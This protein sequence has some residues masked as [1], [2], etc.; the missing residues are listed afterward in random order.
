MFLNGSLNTG[1]IY[2]VDLE[3]D[4]EK[5]PT[6]NKP[7]SLGVSDKDNVPCPI[8]SCAI[9]AETGACYVLFPN[10]MWVEV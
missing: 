10:N 4:I 3:S 2:Y 5:L 6:H 8:G 9:V 1:W 7:G